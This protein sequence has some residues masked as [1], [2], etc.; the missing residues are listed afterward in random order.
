MKIVLGNFHAKLVT[1]NIFK[2]TTGNESL[3]EG[4]NDNGVTVVNFGISKNLVVK[5]TMFP[6]TKTFINTSGPLLMGR[7]KIK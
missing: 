2:V 5:S 4:G 1:Q 6:H 7:L 3:H